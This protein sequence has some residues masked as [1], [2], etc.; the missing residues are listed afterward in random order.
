MA[1]RGAARRGRAGQGLFTAGSALEIARCSGGN[2][3]RGLAWHGG[4]RRGRARQGLFTAGSALEIARCSGGNTGRGPARLGVA[5]QGKAWQGKGCL[6]PAG[7]LKESLVR[8][9]IATSRG[10]AGLGVA[11]RGWARRGKAGA[12]YSRQR[13]RDSALFGWKHRSW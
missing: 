2:T 7:D 5:R 12:V 13:T 9:A 4:A 8:V 10:S 11:G 3:S 6:Q 1:W